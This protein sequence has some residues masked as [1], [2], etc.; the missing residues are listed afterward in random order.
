M[1]I[2]KTIDLTYSNFTLIKK[3]KKGQIKDTMHI[4]ST[5][6]CYAYFI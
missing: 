5:Q 3:I 2:F 6:S 4:S 1:F